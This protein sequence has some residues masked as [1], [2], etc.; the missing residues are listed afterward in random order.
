MIQIF[1]FHLFQNS[2]SKIEETENSKFK[3]EM[4]YRIPLV[5]IIFL[6]LICSFTC[7][8]LNAQEGRDSKLIFGQ[9]AKP[10]QAGQGYI[11]TI[12]GLIYA[13]EVGI[14]PFL[15]VAGGTALSAFLGGEGVL[16]G[17]GLR[18]KLAFPIKENWYAG[19]NFTALRNFGAEFSSPE[20]SYIGMGIITA[21]LEKIQLTFGIGL[22]SNFKLAESSTKLLTTGVI[23]PMFRKVYLV[24]ENQIFLFDSNYSG[25][26]YILQSTLV[27]RWGLERFSFELGVAGFYGDDGD[28]RFG[29]V[30]PQVGFNFHFTK[31]K[32]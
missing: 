7:L 23:V 12:D 27:A 30:L 28:G 29:R 22:V 15:S 9:T 8:N 18:A 5:K 25:L 3:T 6:Y 2:F 10:L 31:S 21:D 13:A 17:G 20:M 16:S 14:T 4:S 32:K 19:V 26:S 1:L 11:Y 24:N